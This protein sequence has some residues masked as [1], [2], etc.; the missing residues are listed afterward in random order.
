MHKINTK[1]MLASYRN[2]NLLVHGSFCSI[3]WLSNLSP[4]W[5]FL[6]SAFS[7]KL[8]VL[9]ILILFDCRISLVCLTE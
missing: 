9:E 1:N 8:A 7:N 6:L 2:T 5:A 3:L 4:Q